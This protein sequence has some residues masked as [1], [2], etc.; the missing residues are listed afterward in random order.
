ME[1]PR[2]ISGSTT[3]IP[4][5]MQ[6]GNTTPIPIIPRSR[7]ATPIPGS[8]GPF[9]ESVLD[10]EQTLSVHTGLPQNPPPPPP[11]PQ[12]Q[13]MDENLPLHVGLG[14][15][16]RVLRTG[17]TSQR[18][19][20]IV[21]PANPQVSRNWNDL[22]AQIHRLAG[23]ELESKLNS[24]PGGLVPP[25]ADHPETDDF[26][27][28]FLKFFQSVRHTPGFK[29]SNCDWITHNCVPTYGRK[30][31]PSGVGL[32]EDDI[33]DIQN[34][35][36]KKYN[37]VWLALKRAHRIALKHNYR[38]FTIAIPELQVGGGD[39]TPRDDAVL[40]I[41]A[42]ID[43]FNHPD[44][45][46]RRRYAID[47]VDI[48]IDPTEAGRPYVAAYEFAWAKLNMGR[49]TRDRPLSR[50]PGAQIGGLGRPFPANLPQLPSLN[51]DSD[52]DYDSAPATPTPETR[53]RYS[54]LRPP[55]PSNWAAANADENTGLSGSTEGVSHGT[56]SDIDAEIGVSEEKNAILEESSTP[57][58]DQ[59]PDEGPNQGDQDIEMP[60]APDLSPQFSKSKSSISQ[61]SGLDAPGAERVEGGHLNEDFLEAVTPNAGDD[62]ETLVA[63]TS[64]K[65]SVAK[66]SQ[67]SN[68]PADSPAWNLFRSTTPSAE[69]SGHENSDK[70]ALEEE[71]PERPIAK[72]GVAAQEPSGQE[73]S[74]ENISFA[75][76]P[77]GESSGG[78]ERE[79][80]DLKPHDM[81]KYIE[82]ARER[83]WGGESQEEDTAGSETERREQLELE[84]A[85]EKEFEEDEKEIERERMERESGV[86]AEGIGDDE[87][88]ESNERE[89]VP[90][91]E[92]VVVVGKNEKEDEH[93][94]RE[95][96]VDE[97]IAKDD[98][99]EFDMESVCGMEEEMVMDFSKISAEQPDQPPTET[100][101]SDQTAEKIRDVQKERNDMEAKIHDAKNEFN[102]MEREIQKAEEKFDHAGK[103]IHK[104]QKKTKEEI[105]DAEKEFQRTQESS[106]KGDH[107]ST[108]EKS[109]FA[110][111]SSTTTQPSEKTKTEQHLEVSYIHEIPPIPEES[112]EADEAGEAGEAGK[113]PSQTTQKTDDT[114]AASLS[115]VTL[116]KPQPARHKRS[117]APSPE[118]PSIKISFSASPSPSPPGDKAPET[119][120]P[121]LNLSESA[122]RKGSAPHEEQSGKLK[123]LALNFP[124]LTPGLKE[125]RPSIMGLEVPKQV[126]LEE[127]VFQSAIQSQSVQGASV[128]TEFKLPSFTATAIS[129]SASHA[130]TPFSG[131]MP[132]SPTA[133]PTVHT[134]PKV[135]TLTKKS[136]TARPPVSAPP[137]SMGAE[138]ES[139][140]Q[141]LLPQIAQSATA[142]LNTEIQQLLHVGPQNKLAEGPS[143]S[144][145][146]NAPKGKPA[147]RKRGVHAEVAS[148]EA[149]E[150]GLDGAYWTRGASKRR[151]RGV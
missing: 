107:L 79:W 23:P 136:S 138:I 112:H 132:M 142:I 24:H 92:E 141:V 30:F 53:R 110:G 145:L 43:F 111:Q 76:T 146:T 93:E 128:G 100:T 66:N 77:G 121:G 2:D 15:R 3:P 82:E 1:T 20:M 32:D 28:P 65:N 47:R 115:P 114:T 135:Q 97:G 118:T 37:S 25:P 11:A 5:L 87:M 64:V 123:L 98:E 134:S 75:P 57:S 81:A 33:E 84:Q 80:E 31:D 109:P 38:H 60:D 139:Q 108:T 143:V 50:T 52:I 125:H 95:S 148:L 42:V 69:S 58:E 94:G 12:P 73:T 126:V 85:I 41:G 13:N 83:E 106:R 18:W 14:G 59:L 103:E 90:E 35:N 44:W 119:E 10:N 45:G 102:E 56:D 21:C 67:A 36:G 9:A 4:T 54:V 48:I 19:D 71:S 99:E 117:P 147:K 51:T 89:T 62:E 127:N 72:E 133:K 120:I 151:R 26:N 86:E 29:M 17:I 140:P 113:Q 7:S 149:Q 131:V 74:D 63:D 70:G 34:R 116:T 124:E 8:R 104:E 101:G 78:S 91:K 130:D 39:F 96:G 150:K 122:I 88:T 55:L 49:E 129:A 144:A 22:T 137:P 27:S 68:S 16:L 46:L 61:S 40:T 105:Q 6:S